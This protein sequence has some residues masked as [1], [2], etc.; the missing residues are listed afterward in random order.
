M[1]KDQ[2]DRIEMVPNELAG[3]KLTA[4]CT[5]CEKQYTGKRG[6]WSEMNCDKYCQW[7]VP[8]YPGATAFRKVPIHKQGIIPSQALNIIFYEPDKVTVEIIKTAIKA[9]PMVHKVCEVV[10]R[11]QMGDYLVKFISKDRTAFRQT[12][13]P[14]EIGRAFQGYTERIVNE[15]NLNGYLDAVIDRA[16]GVD[17]FLK[18]IDNEA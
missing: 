7:L 14:K 1:K 9:L 17:D 16:V 12:G 15:F 8:D 10:Y 11:K 5:D 18:K 2:I 13:T 3:P 4:F 6:V